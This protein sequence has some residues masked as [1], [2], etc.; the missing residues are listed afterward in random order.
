MAGRASLKS[1]RVQAES[2]LNGA[3]AAARPHSSL[4]F[5]VIFSDAFVQ[6]KRLPFRSRRR[7]WLKLCLVTK[8]IGACGTAEDRH[9]T[10]DKKTA[11]GRFD[12]AA[13]L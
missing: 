2:R 9:A 8:V 10:C 4:N 11:A 13:F 7:D 3:A 1:S 12:G 5:V 6:S